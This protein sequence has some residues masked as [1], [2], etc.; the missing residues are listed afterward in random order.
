MTL[1]DVETPVSLADSMSGAPGVPGTRLSMVSATEPVD[2][3]VF[4]SPKIVVE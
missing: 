4:P 1:S 3:A 2:T